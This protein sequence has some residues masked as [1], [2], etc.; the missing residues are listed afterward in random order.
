MQ[1][2]QIVQKY[3]GGKGEAEVEEDPCSCRE[4]DEI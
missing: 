2:K 3:T 4:T 1:R